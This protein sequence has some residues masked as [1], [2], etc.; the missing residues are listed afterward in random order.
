[1]KSRKF[2]A[3]AFFAI[4]VLALIFSILCSNLRVGSWEWDKE[5]GGDAYTGI[6]NAAAQAANNTIYLN[7]NF[8]KICGYFLIITSATFASLGVYHLIK[9]YEEKPVARSV[10]KPQDTYKPITPVKNEDTT[11]PKCNA[12]MSAGRSTCWECGYSFPN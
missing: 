1:M 4:A 8:C 7:E 9:A 3:F 2:L 10:Q 12:K 6:Q 11:C 5:Y